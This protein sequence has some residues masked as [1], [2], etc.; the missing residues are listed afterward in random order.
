MN[1]KMS[2]EF[3][4]ILSEIKD[5]NDLAE[6]GRT[7]KEISRELMVSRAKAQEYLRIYF[8]GEKYNN[9]V[10]RKNFEIQ[11]LLRDKKIKFNEKRIIDLVEH[12]NG[13]STIK[14]E[15]GFESLGDVRHALNKIY[16]DGGLEHE[17]LKVEI[18]VLI[19]RKKEQRK[20]EYKANKVSK[21]VISYF[22]KN[23]KMLEMR[24]EGSTLEEIGEVYGVTRERI[25]QILKRLIDE[26][27]YDGFTILNKEEISKKKHEKHASKKHAEFVIIKKEHE[28]AL[29]DA[30]N[31]GKN[32][33]QIKD[34]LD[35]TSTEV[36][37][38]LGILKKEG[39]ISYFKPRGS[40]GPSE[41][42]LDIAYK[43]IVNM[44][45]KGSSLEEIGRELG[46]SRIWVAQ[47]IRKMRDMGMYVP[48]LHNMSNREYLRDWNKINTRSKEILQL[49]KSGV[50][51]NSEIE[52]KL[53][54]YSGS[55]SRHIRDYIKDEVEEALREAD[56][57]H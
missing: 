38:C 10:A 42:E 1:S 31:S 47:K 53:G 22:E 16:F 56:K 32:T 5:L 19:I 13:L 44:R 26:G 55:V 36:R 41:E 24:N 43:T 15:I 28:S 9:N 35:L 12:G 14:D 37:E 45:E 20:K 21:K 27:P 7:I 57:D 49:I 3:L 11:L 2:D 8:Y 25:R 23:K 48:D 51:S 4:E 50:R 29:I 39:K 52:K 33:Q 30:Y 46:Y 34:D 40:Q 54:L 6:Q 18:N 17:K